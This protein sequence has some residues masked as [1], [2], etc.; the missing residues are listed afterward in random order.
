MKKCLVLLMAWI[1]FL[2]NVSPVC[3][4]QGNKKF[5][6]GISYEDI[7]DEIEAY[8]KK[9]KAT[10][11]GMEVAVF[12]R[13]GI[14][15]QNQFGY[16]NVED[17]VS[18][19]ENSVFGWGSITKMLV[20]VSVMQL[21]EKDKIDLETDICNYLPENFLTNL[22]YK[23]PVTMLNLMNHNAGFQEM[24]VDG[25]L[26]DYEDVLPLG[27]QLKAHEPEQ[28]FEPGVVTAYSNWGTA[29]AGYIVEQISGQSFDAYV[30][31]NIFERLGM[32]HTAIR[33][34]LSDNEWVRKERLKLQCYDTDGTLH[35]K[36]FYHIPLYP[37]GMCAS[38]LGDLQKFAQSLLMKEGEGC[39]LFQNSATLVEML[40]ATSYYG[41]TELPRISHGFL[42]TERGVHV[43]GHGGNSYGCSAN[44]EIEPDSGIG[45]VV[46]TNQYLEE[47]YTDGMM[48]LFFGS[49]KDSELADYNQQGIEGFMLDARTVL[50][51]P[52]SLESMRSEKS[53]FGSI[54]AGVGGFWILS[55]S[56]GREIISVSSDN[57]YL[58]LSPL[59]YIPGV[60]LMF[61]TM[62]GFCYALGT[63][64]LGGCIIRPILK[65]QKKKQ[66]IAK[67]LNWFDR[68]NYFVCILISLGMINLEL[69]FLKMF[70]N[71]FC[72]QY[73]WLIIVNAVI[74]ILLILSA[75]WMIVNWRKVDLSKRKKIQY[76]ITLF[77]LIIVIVA[78]IRWQ[79]YCFWAL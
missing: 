11:A 74:L 62:V 9:H 27:E 58:I 22:K 52:I 24:L 29:L 46:M 56:Q 43:L 18:V 63:C 33:P 6:S 54:D 73:L 7:D 72:G 78:A 16:I 75:G 14:I 67:K 77:F 2:S 61:L 8:V 4:A 21:W 76:A 59:E 1:M 34:D 13:D 55:E 38:T 30:K 31:E 19:K 10:T 32:E 42:T 44:M 23:T 47:T 5:P 48:E 51:G 49:I 66:G 3:A 70:E 28:V 12:D 79:V 35:E 65:I 64:V 71:A 57:D 17:K 53:G 50:K 37:A 15:Y 69:I 41:D 25:Y 40:T 20:W 39:P 60:V 45:V 26:E 68:W 36:N